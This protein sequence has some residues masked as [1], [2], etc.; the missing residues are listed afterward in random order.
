[1][2][3]YG[4]GF[5]GPRGWFDRWFGGHG[6]GRG[7]DRGYRGGYDRGYGGGYG[8][9]Y[10]G[11]GGYGPRTGPDPNRQGYGAEYDAPHTR[12]YLNPGLM[13]DEAWGGAYSAGDAQYAGRRLFNPRNDPRSGGGYDRQYRRAD[14]GYGWRR[15]FG[16][17][18][19]RGR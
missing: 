10:R 13:V 17:G 4:R 3:D 6:Q 5:R 19:D 11:A 16:R 18:Y 9:D 14:P 12:G 8:R 2:A 7:Y 15:P 1:M